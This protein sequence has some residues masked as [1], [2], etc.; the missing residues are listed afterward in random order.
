METTRIDYL[1]HHMCEENPYAQRVHDERTRFGNEELHEL[2]WDLRHA[3]LEALQI[4]EREVLQ[5]ELQERLEG[6][7]FQGLKHRDIVVTLL[8][9]LHE[10][11]SRG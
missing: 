10:M 9:G 7:Q 5:V 4:A 11:A 2:P 6:N 8:D 3:T 1:A